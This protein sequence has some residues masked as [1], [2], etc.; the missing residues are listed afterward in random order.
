MG[1]GYLFVRSSCGVRNLELVR[2]L[3]G[4]SGGGGSKAFKGWP[5]VEPTGGEK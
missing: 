4:Y 5:W 3:I 1:I 2:A